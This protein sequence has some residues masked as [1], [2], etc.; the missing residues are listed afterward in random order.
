MKCNICIYGV[1][2]MF[3]ELINKLKVRKQQLQKHKTNNDIVETKLQEEID[4]KISKQDNIFKIEIDDYISIA[5]FVNKTNSGDEYRILGMLCNC[6]LWNSGNQKVNK[7]VYYLIIIDNRIYNI[8]FTKDKIKID[9]RI[10][11]RID[12][13]SNKENIIQERVITYNLNKNEYSYYSAKHESDGN[14]YYTKYYN[15]NRK[16]SLGELD[17]SEEETFEEVNSVFSNLETING[18]KNILDIETLKDFILKDL[19]N[20]SFQR[21]KTL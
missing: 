4:V 20:N 13:Y 18:I 9:E 2:V 11:L 1:I 15:K 8:L 10:K 3:R 21:K 16:Y 6:V 7:G 19:S 17:L 5:D 14:T 12:E